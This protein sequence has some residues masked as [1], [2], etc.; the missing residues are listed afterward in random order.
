[1]KYMNKLPT[2]TDKKLKDPSCKV[3]YEVTKNNKAKMSVKG[4]PASII[5]GLVKAVK[6]LSKS[7]NIEIETL[8]DYAK[9]ELEKVKQEGKNNAKD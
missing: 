7:L 3:V 8:I 5:Q 2:K 9:A 4:N 1:M 6:M